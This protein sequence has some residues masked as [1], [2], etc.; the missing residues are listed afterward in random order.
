MNKR[1][2]IAVLALVSGAAFLSAADKVD[3]DPDHSHHNTENSGADWFQ[4][5]METIDPNGSAQ[6]M[7]K[8][9]P[10][11]DRKKRLQIDPDLVGMWKELYIDHFAVLTMRKDGTYTAYYD[12]GDRVIV[13]RGTW[14]AKN[15]LLTLTTDRGMTA[16]TPYLIEFGSKTAM[17][18]RINPDSGSREGVH[19][20]LVG[21]NYDENADCLLQSGI[22]EYDN[23]LWDTAV[24]ESMRRLKG[25]GAK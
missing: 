4:H 9:V 8:A 21:D 20:K 10:K 16:T 14:S 6:H 23:D 12:F 25:K 5:I 22:Y 2:L 15:E 7:R 11:R 3:N 1:F 19:E 18:L 13:Q 24:R 17:T